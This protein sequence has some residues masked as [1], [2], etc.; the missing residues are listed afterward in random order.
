MV[1]KK[2]KKKK[3]KKR[4][5]NEQTQPI[6]EIKENKELVKEEIVEKE[7]EEPSIEPPKK[8]KRKKL[9]PKAVLVLFIILIPI[10][11]LVAIHFLD[12]PK[13]EIKKEVKKEPKVEEK[14][15]EEEKEEPKV[16]IVNEE[17]TSRPFAVMIN[18][19]GV[20]RPLQSGLQ[21]AYI[22]YEIIVEGGI[23]RYMA[24]FLDQET[25]RIGSIRSS[26]HYYLDY[27]LEN[28]SIYV[29]HGQSPQAQ[30]DFYSLGI[31]RIVADN[32]K[33]GWRDKTLGVSSEH[34]LF[35]SIAKLK[36]GVGSKR[37]TRNKDLLLKYSVDPV[38]LSSIEGSKDANN[39][40]IN[41]SNSV[42]SSYEYDSENQVYKRFVNG[43]AHTDYVTKKQ[44]TF[45]N[46]I[47]YQ[48]GNYTIAGDEKGRQNLNNIGSG[49]GYYISN[50]KAIPIKWSKSS[51]SS[52]T[53]YM[54]DN[55]ED[56]VV[57]DG[58]TFI[59]IQPK[60]RTLSIS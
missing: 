52:Q 55:G 27:A 10:I 2:K 48:V 46:I 38:D 35:T 22:M 53:K 56:L 4:V 50:G 34:T 42:T 57:N 6:H 8:R 11:V 51:R 49:T 23:T 12:K 36:N 30:S 58:N 5:S 17:S 1:T 40:S 54:L 41:Y 45:K 44:Y 33:T 20:A 59:Q 25:E 13:E 32:S 9:N 60:G 15:V 47:V 14:V 43:K 7:V 24:L 18:N 29:H 26:R 37:T 31:D 3:K 16:K 39:V 19:V 28:D 21:D